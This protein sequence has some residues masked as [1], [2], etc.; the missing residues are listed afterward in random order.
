[1]YVFLEQ[2]FSFIDESPWYKSFSMPGTDFKDINKDKQI[3]SYYYIIKIN[4][5]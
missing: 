2:N 3:K 5:K 1:M 4:M